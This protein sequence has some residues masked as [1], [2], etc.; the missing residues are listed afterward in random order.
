MTKLNGASAAALRAQG[1]DP[2]KVRDGLRAA[3][4]QGE[5]APG[6]ELKLTA[7]AA[8]NLQRA[9]ALAAKESTDHVE[10]RHLLVAILPVMVGPAGVSKTA[11]VEGLPLNR[12]TD[13][14]EP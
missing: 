6:A 4:G 10:E 12:H 1:N 11:I 13:L 9:E 14:G 5:A 7:R 2:K 8:A 3:L